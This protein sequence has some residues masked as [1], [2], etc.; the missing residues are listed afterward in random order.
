[1][2]IDLESLTAPVSDDSPAGPDLSYESSRQEIEGAFERAAAGEEGAEDIDWRETIRLIEDEAGR[3]RDI[4]LAIYMM[5][6]GARAGRLEVVE[7]GANLLAGLCENLWDSVHPELEDYGF[8]GRKG[9]CE[10]L[11][12]IG[13]FINPL[14]RTVLV[15]H[16]RLGRYS[17]ADFDRFRENGSSEDGY[18][19]FK[20]LLEATPDE[21][22]QAVVDR[23]G[24]IADSIRRAD[25]V[26]TARADG[27]TS[28]NFQPT[29]DAIGLLRQSV[30]SFMRSPGAAPDEAGAAD[31]LADASA[32][33]G[34]TDYSGTI[35]SRSDVIR[36]LDAIAQ[37]YKHKEPGS[38]VPFALRRARDWVSLDFLQV[39]EDIAPNSLDEAK[40]VLING[41]D[42]SSSGLSSGSDDGWSSDS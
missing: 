12:K 14:R 11:T 20:A 42:T 22:L 7:D 36:A 30:S 8:Q 9:P 23:L 1:M 33:G 13:E 29:Y 21:D 19:M 39:L 17:G 34:G 16:P 31:A 27:D 25:A 41:R 3:T 24:G 15:E 32:G 35:S 18:G 37:Y 28:T 40:R 4:W 5:R 38:P 26:M 10:S 6:A 2:T